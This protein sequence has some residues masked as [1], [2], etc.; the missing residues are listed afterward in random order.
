V[1]LTLTLMLTN[2]SSRLYLYQT[3]RLFSEPYQPNTE[4]KT[5][6]SSDLAIENSP[7]YLYLYLLRTHAVAVA[8]GAGWISSTLMCTHKLHSQSNIGYQPMI[9]K[10][11]PNLMTILSL[12]SEPLCAFF[13]H[14]ST[15]C[16]TTTAIQAAAINLH[17]VYRD[18]APSIVQIPRVHPLRPMLSVLYT[19][20]DA[21]RSRITSCLVLQLRCLLLQAL[22]PFKVAP[23]FNW[24][25]CKIV[26]TWTQPA[27]PGEVSRVYGNGKHV[28]LFTLSSFRIPLSLCTLF[29]N[30][31]N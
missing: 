9:F 7:T 2:P 4:S 3:F 12:Y 19:T 15:P 26:N 5:L 13:P 14:R 18:D 22:L 10:Y 16:T 29:N 23:N 11:I 21:P 30:S 1:N 28:F 31:M 25:E 20:P 8:F 27:F 17:S 6:L 24:S